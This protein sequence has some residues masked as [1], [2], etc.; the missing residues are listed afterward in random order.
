MDINGVITKE[1]YNNVTSLTYEQFSD[2]LMRLV[3]LCVEESLKALPAVV[4]HISKETEYLNRLSNE[5]YI[6]NKELRGPKKLVASVI[7]TVE[8]ENPGVT[9]EEV[10]HKAAI[11]AK[12]IIASKS[13]PQE[14][15]E[16]TM[17]RFEDK[18][19]DI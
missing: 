17:R 5:F 12:Q 19:K 9:Y 2:Y 7:E 16:I 4:G 14:T 13:I 18:L 11:K 10:L 1:E 15:K 6:N 8:A 3:K